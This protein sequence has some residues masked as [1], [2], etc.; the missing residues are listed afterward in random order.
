MY[1]FNSNKQF[2]NLILLKERKERILLHI[3]NNEFLK[4]GKEMW[5]LPA[6]SHVIL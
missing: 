2:P 5:N 3:K 4:K 1:V 6:Q